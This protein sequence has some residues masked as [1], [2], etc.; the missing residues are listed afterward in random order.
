[1]KLHK[2]VA[3]LL[4]GVLVLAVAT[5]THAVNCI[6]PDS[7]GT[8]ALPPAGCTYTTPNGD[9]QI[10]NGLP[11]STTID[12]DASLHTFFSVVTAPGGNLGGETE[13]YNAVLQMPMVGTGSLAGFN[14]FLAMQVSNQSESAPRVP[15]AP[16][17][18]FGRDMFSMT[19]QIFGDPDFDFL[20][21]T[22][23]TAFGLPSPG[24]TTLT[25]LGGVGSNWNVDSFFDIH[26]EIDFQGAPGSILE[27]FGGTTTGVT[28]F[29]LGMPIPEPTTGLLSLMG[30]GAVCLRRR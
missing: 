3:P 4:G 9:L 24:S 2:K 20:R 21:I 23:G 11:G 27:G 29:Q 12:I 17:Q 13:T 19:G 6:V 28:R 18:T 26:Y 10:S 30:I 16:V 5:T 22:A 14:R 1:M 8:A 7:S 25:R 15:N